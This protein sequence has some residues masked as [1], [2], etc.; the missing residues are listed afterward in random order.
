[1]IASARKFSDLV[2]DLQRIDRNP[3]E[4]G[5]TFRA[6]GQTILEAFVRH[7]GYCSGAVWL[8]DGAAECLRLAAFSPGLEAPPTLSGPI[9]L[10]LLDRAL[11]AD[12]FLAFLSDRKS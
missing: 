4:G 2:G 10:Q 5:S 1:M 12:P 3:R 11:A 9:P 8:R 6:H 7:A